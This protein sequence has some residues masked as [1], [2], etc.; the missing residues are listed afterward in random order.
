M[1]RSSRLD[2]NQNQAIISET[3]TRGITFNYSE[4]F[5]RIIELSTDNFIDWKTNILY[6][7][8]INNLEEY[9]IKEKVKKIRKKDIK[10]GLENYPIDQFD[11]ALVY[12]KN[13]SKQDIKNDILVKW[14]ICNSLGE[15]TKRLLQSQ[16]KTSYQIWTTLNKSFTKGIEHRKCDLRNKI[17]NL[18][19]NVKEDIH[20]FIANLENLMEELEKIDTD[21]PDSNKVGILNRALPQDLRFINVFQYKNQWKTCSEYV[22]NIIPEIIFSNSKE[23]KD[24]NG[25]DNK[26][27]LN[28]GLKENLQNKKSSSF[29]RK[30]RKNGRCTHCRKIGHYSSECWFNKKRKNIN[31]K[32]YKN[33]KHNKPTKRSIKNKGKSNQSIYALNNDISHKTKPS[34]IFSTDYNSKHCIELN[35]AKLNREQNQNPNNEENIITCWILDSGASIH[36]TYQLSILTNIRQCDERITL[37]NGKSIHIKQ[38]GDF[39]GFI[40]NNKFILKNVYYSPH[41]KK[42]LISINSL[43]KE[44]YK[45]IFNNSHGTPMAILYDAFGNKITTMKPS[46]TNTFIIY[47]TKQIIKYK[48]DYHEEINQINLCQC[49]EY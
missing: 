1:P 37:A 12:E 33:Y 25:N 5:N 7:L 43:I 47:I 14:I 46:N 16:S 10:E 3:E 4:N 42:N 18:K 41:I 2:N 45:V 39:T 48:N 23:H 9:V 30:G 31:N 22:K 44:N 15:E 24:L 38:I 6:L 8:S 27:Q 28:L 40:N 36:V 13:T 17:I 20:I 29:R 11:D 34:N 26:N 49:N 32:K 35:Y 21:I 19:Y